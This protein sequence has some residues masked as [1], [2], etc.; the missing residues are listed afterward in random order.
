MLKNL[1][2]NKLVILKV[3]MLEWLSRWSLYLKKVLF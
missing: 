3:K 2:L 1:L